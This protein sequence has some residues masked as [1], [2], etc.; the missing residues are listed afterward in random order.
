MTAPGE[1]GGDILLHV[2]F[3]DAIQECVAMK[4]SL[5]MC[6]KRADFSRIQDKILCSILKCTE[7]AD[8]LNVSL[9][10]PADAVSYRIDLEF[11]LERNN[12]ENDPNISLFDQNA[13]SF[14]IPMTV[15][16]SPSELDLQTRHQLIWGRQPFKPQ[17]LSSENRA[18]LT[19]NSLAKNKIISFLEKSGDQ[20]MLDPSVTGTAN[21][22]I[23]NG[24]AQPLSAVD[25]WDT[26]QSTQEEL[27]LAVFNILDIGSKGYL[28]PE[29]IYA[30]SHNKDIH[31]MLKYTVFCTSTVSNVSNNNKQVLTPLG[32]GAGGRNSISSQSSLISAT[33]SLTACTG[34]MMRD[35]VWGL[36][37][38]GCV[39]LPAVIERIHTNYEPSGA[40]G[41]GI[42]FGYYNSVV[43]ERTPP[44]A[45]FTYDIWYPINERVLNQSRAMS[46]S[47]TL[48]S[49]PSTQDASILH[50]KAVYGERNVCAYAFDID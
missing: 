30:I 3:R 16:A 38:K 43:S 32:N 48:L 44:R 41:G 21:S 6:E 12:P 10:L 22:S 34:Q 8:L 50:P 5:V 26:I 23:A 47:R 49:L 37:A 39:W 24:P 7:E 17:P 35:C 40:V 45:Y 20:T 46:V 33:N 27:L 11:C 28:L 42:G 29:D 2:D 18:G 9:T 15:T 25:I 14:D 36:H 1:S 4:A 19:A 31:N 13:F